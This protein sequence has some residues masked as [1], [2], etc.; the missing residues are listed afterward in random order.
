MINSELS[1]V[2]PLP[3][4]WDRTSLSLRVA[5]QAG[6]GYAGYDQVRRGGRLQV[7]RRPVKEHRRLV[8]L[9]AWSVVNGPFKL[10]SN[11]TSGQVTFVPNPDWSGT[12]KP[13]ISKFVELPFTSEAAIYNQ[14]KSGGPSAV[15]VG[16]H[17]VAVRAPAHFAGRVGL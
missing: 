7:P 17:A 2:F 13:A 3:M 16:E 15:T 1:Q 8:D 14:V 4:A 12:P 5:V 11:N 9:A 10:Q 6:I